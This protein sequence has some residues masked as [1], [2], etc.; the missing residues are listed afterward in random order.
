[1]F[2][3]KEKNQENSIPGGYA[4]LKT[5]K[6]FHFLEEKAQGENV[7]MKNPKYEYRNPN[8]LQI[9]NQS[10]LKSKF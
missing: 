5:P 9:R 10:N 2:Y 7:E 4:N 3:K 6:F 8:K 1:M